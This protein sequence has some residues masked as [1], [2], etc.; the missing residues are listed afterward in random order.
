MPAA[1]IQR[2]VGHPRLRTITQLQ[3]CSPR[4]L[5]RQ[6]VRSKRCVGAYWQAR[7]PDHALILP[8][9]THRRGCDSRERH[10]R[11][12]PGVVVC[13]GFCLSVDGCLKGL[14]PGLCHGVARQRCSLRLSRVRSGHSWATGSAATCCRACSHLALT[15]P[16]GGTAQRRF[17]AD[18]RLDRIFSADYRFDR[19]ALHRPAAFFVG[20]AGADRPNRLDEPGR[21]RTFGCTCNQD[22]SVCATFQKSQYLVLH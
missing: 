4:K 17:A 2:K 5:V 3:V 13:A 18:R 11:E 20:V 15:R 7:S 9:R 21:L 19:R 6:Q 16:G 12:K 10:P 8:Y 1:L 14:R 22:R